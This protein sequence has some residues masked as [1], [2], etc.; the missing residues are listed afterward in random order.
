MLLIANNQVQRHS[1]RFTVWL[2]LDTYSFARTVFAVISL[3]VGVVVG[4]G[5]GDGN[6]AAA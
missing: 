2:H 5:F 4:L 3:A 1:R 6:C